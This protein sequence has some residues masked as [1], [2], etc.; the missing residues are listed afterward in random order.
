MGEGG[1]EQ[2]EKEDCVCTLYMK[3]L[4]VVMT[5]IHY[6]CREQTGLYEPWAQLCNKFV[7]SCHNYREVTILE[8]SLTQ[9]VQESCSG[10]RPS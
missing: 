3:T 10:S 2:E 4:C 9:Y 7:G 6:S 5:P 1:G 8:N